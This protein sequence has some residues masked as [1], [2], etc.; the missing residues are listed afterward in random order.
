MLHYPLWMVIIVTS[1]SSRSSRNKDSS[2]ATIRA[3]SMA[4]WV[5]P[6]QY[7]RVG[8]EDVYETMKYNIIRF[9]MRLSDEQR[10]RM[11]LA[12]K[13][14]TWSDEGWE[15]DAIMIEFVGFR[16]KMYAMRV[17]GKDT[18]KAKGVKSNIVARTIT[19]DDYTRCLNEEI[20]MTRHQS[21]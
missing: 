7:K 2:D 12:N 13:K 14:Q 9:N 21:I 18:K 10:V 4:S 20:E 16:A 8:C 6:T 15:Y 11:P 3:I 19:F 1:N 5:H 17:D